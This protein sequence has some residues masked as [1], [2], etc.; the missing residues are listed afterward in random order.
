MRRSNIVKKD[1]NQDKFVSSPFYLN[2]LLWDI[3][4]QLKHH[5]L[6][7]Y[8]KKDFVTYLKS[9]LKKSFYKYVINEVQINV[10]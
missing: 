10:L 8:Y 6:S 1:T 5:Y 2:N 3:K 7:Y 4:S 9:F